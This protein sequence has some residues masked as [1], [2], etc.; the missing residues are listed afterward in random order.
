[1]SRRLLLPVALFGVLV[2]F[3]DALASRIADGARLSRTR[4]DLRSLR[5]S[6]A[7]YREYVGSYPTDSQGLDVLV[8]RPARGSG[9][10]R[11]HKVMECVPMDAWGS[12]YR[13]RYLPNTPYHFEVFSMGPDGLPGNE[14]DLSSLD[15]E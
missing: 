12:R 2:L 9:L 6:V 4:E 11:W 5:S 14:D 3:A 13:Y 10:E 7:T 1:M 15:L 8:S